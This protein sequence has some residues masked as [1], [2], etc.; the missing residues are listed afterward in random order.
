MNFHNRSIKFRVGEDDGRYN[1]V[2]PNCVANP[3]T[4]AFR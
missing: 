2:I 1:S 4:T 3:C